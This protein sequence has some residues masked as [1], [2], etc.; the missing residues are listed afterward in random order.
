MKTA[1]ISVNDIIKILKSWASEK[2][3]PRNDGWVKSEYEERI[4]KI[5]TES[6]KL[7]R[8]NK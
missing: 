3:N 6:S 1:N 5:F 4:K 8:K 2:N 7:L